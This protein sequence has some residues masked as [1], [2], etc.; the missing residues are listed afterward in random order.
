MPSALNTSEGILAGL[1]AG[2]YLFQ[3]AVVEI[4]VDVL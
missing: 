1:I 4:T 2:E 3:D